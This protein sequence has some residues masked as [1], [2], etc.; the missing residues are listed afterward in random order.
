M[1]N[2]YILK[3][4]NNNDDLRGNNFS[5]VI[6]AEADI[7]VGDII[8]IPDLQHDYI[9]HTFLVKKRVIKFTKN[10]YAEYHIDLFVISFNYEDWLDSEDAEKTVEELCDDKD[11]RRL[12]ML[13]TSDLKYDTPEFYKSLAH[14]IYYNISDKTSYD[15]NEAYDYI[16]EMIRG[17]YD[18]YDL[19]ID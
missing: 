2:V 16:I 13:S 6:K 3:N 10:S 15:P 7:K 4:F 14:V 18:L 17:K 11:I 1:V 12:A 9:N 5:K 8:Q 19:K